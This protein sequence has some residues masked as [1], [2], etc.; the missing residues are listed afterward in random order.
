MTID[1]NPFGLPINMV[2]VSISWKKKKGGKALGWKRKL[3]EKD[4]ARASWKMI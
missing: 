2:L 3:K 1:T 4:E